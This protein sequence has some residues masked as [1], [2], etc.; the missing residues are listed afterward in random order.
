VVAGRHTVGIHVAV[1]P[2]NRMTTGRTV[3]IAGVAAAIAVA[4]LTGL[5][6][7]MQDT[8]SALMVSMGS[9]CVTTTRALKYPN[10][11]LVLFGDSDVERWSFPAIDGVT[12]VNRGHSGDHVSDL[13]ARFDRDVVAEHP[14]AVVIWGFDNDVVDAREN[15]LD[16]AAVL[17]AIQRSYTEMID[18][19]EGHGI[20]PI[21]ATDVTFGQ[22]PGIGAS[23]RRGVDRL[24]GR[25]Q[26]ED[27]MNAMVLDG[28][29][30]L[31]DLASTRSLLLLDLQ[32]ALSNRLQY[33]RY[34]FVED[35]GT[36]ITTAGY[37]ALNKLVVPVL[38]GHL[39]GRR[40]P[41]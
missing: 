24:L 33:R 32:A 23:L 38:R 8:S 1:G 7:L 39:T 40:S 26:F 15:N 27:R 41:S 37:A 17:S 25:T 30:W 4:G 19:A 28:N 36:H 34:E 22:R 9:C 10:G 29:A 21:L 31:R 2:A 14:R 6:P 18:R 12:V 5:R 35:D 20:E 13:L 11:P 3:L 16:A